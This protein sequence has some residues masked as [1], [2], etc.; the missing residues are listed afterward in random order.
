[1]TC[2]SFRQTLLCHEA[3]AID[4]PCRHGPGAGR[5]DSPATP[6]ARATRPP[7]VSEFAHR[8]EHAADRQRDGISALD[9]LI[10]RHPQSA[11]FD[12]LSRGDAE[13]SWP[14]SSS[15]RSASGSWTS[16]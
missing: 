16:T 7:R 3:A 8:T 15:G 6:V 11:T 12:E 10:R 1:M 13:R 4:R 5:S 14:K 2:R 9:E